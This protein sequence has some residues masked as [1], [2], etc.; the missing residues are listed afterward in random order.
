MVF[1]NPGTG[2]FIIETGNFNEHTIEIFNPLHQK[3]I[4]QKIT[5]GY[6]EIDLT[7]YPPGIYYFVFD[8][9]RS[10]KIIIVSN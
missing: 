7:K 1:P 3:I 5:E 8:S 10:G 4:Q 9:F 2:I 6:A